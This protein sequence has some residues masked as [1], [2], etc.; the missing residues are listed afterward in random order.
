[1]HRRLLLA[2]F[3]IAS[4]CA[5]ELNGV[6]DV[7]Q[8]TTPGTPASGY[9]RISVSSSTHLLTCTNSD[10]SSCLPAGSSPGGTNGQVQINNA[11]AFGGI[12]TTG[13][14]NAVLATSPT[15]VT[16]ALG[17][18]SALVLT[19]ATGLPNAGLI[20]PATTVNGQTCTLGSTCTV[21]A[22]PST[23]IIPVT[24]NLLAGSGTANSAVSS[25]IA[26][27]NVALLATA[28]V[29][30]QLQTVNLSG[31]AVPTI[32][33][34]GNVV[35]VGAS[36]S[37]SRLVNVAYAGQGFFSSY[38]IDGTPASPT[39]IVSGDQIGGFNTFGYDGT[40]DGGPLTSVRSFANQNFTSGAHGTY[41]DI[42]TTPNGT[43]AAVQVIQFN[44]DGSVLI[45]GTATGGSQGVGTVNISGNY[46]VNAVLVDTIS[47]TNTLTNKSISGSTNTLSNIANASLT[48]SSITFGATAQAL[49]STV[50]N[51]N[52]V[53]V[54]PT[55]AGTGGFT[56]LLASSTVTFSGISGSIQCL[57]VSSA[58]VVTGTG[59]DCGSGGGSSAFS[60]LTSSTNTTAAMVVGT[61]ASLGVSGTGTIAATSAPG[62]GITG[63]VALANGG[64]SASLTASNG[65]IFYSTASAGAILTGTATAGLALLSGATAA[66][67]WSASAPALLG[68][69]N[70]FTANGALST[71]SGP[72]ALFNG[73]WI[74]GGSATTTKPYFLIETSG[75]TSTGWSTSGTAL[76]I[77]ASS[78]C[79]S[80]ER[81]IDA[82]NNGTTEFN[83]QCNGNVAITASLTIGAANSINPASFA[84]NGFSLL[85][86]N[87]STASAVG[88]KLA[89][90]TWSQTSGSNVAVEVI[91]TYNQAS[92]T[93]S[94]TDLLINRTQTA[95]GSGT[96]RLFDA[97]VGG[98]TKFNISNTGYSQGLAFQS[99]GTTFSVSGCATTSALTGGATAGSFST[100]TTGTCTAVVT[101]GGA[102]TATNGWN[103]SVSDQTTA[104]LF[105]QTASSATTATLSGVSATGDTISFS[106]IAY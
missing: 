66:P 54:G 93:A 21:T 19:N 85:T 79:G 9:S 31:V 11:G 45:P 43:T 87:N 22:A 96:Q 55:T 30:T 20:N 18:P 32:P 42:T 88:L 53:N 16:P 83:V 52:A 84:A 106:C 103:C 13:S 37:S 90:G 92:G 77:N 99:I 39:A 81:L 104:N 33:T 58:G 6:L 26:P 36:A 41:L 34:N 101:F 65:G 50:T 67:T 73:T 4:A 75:A 23:T 102:A 2:L 59:S 69:N 17:T 80:S 47:G 46:Y 15:L 14:G 44:A 7:I 49:G 38:R 12:A 72:G 94:N 5:A 60:A 89:S 63:T 64:T 62:S 61:G 97:Q 57:H 98:S 68:A 1:M 95:V 28:N 100:T 27:A 40:T 76:G 8:I 51:L 82:Q 48:N 70:I 35:I 91:P 25:G 105:R 56:T 29:F 78:G 86:S 71:G 74:T 3:F 24:S 10:S